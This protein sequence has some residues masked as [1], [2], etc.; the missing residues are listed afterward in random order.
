MGNKQ[1]KGGNPGFKENIGHL[2]SNAELGQKLKNVKLLSEYDSAQLEKLAAVVKMEEHNAGTMIVKQGESGRGFYIIEKGRVEVL[3]DESG[4]ESKIADLYVGDYFGEFALLHNAARGASVRAKEHTTTF[5]LGRDDFQTLFDTRTLT[6][7]KRVAVSA[8][9]EDNSYKPPSGASKEKTDAQV[10]LILEAI[11]QSPLF[12]DL[13]LELK[14]QVIA[15]MHCETIAAGEKV[16]LQGDKKGDLFYAVEEGEFDIFVDGN[17]VSVYGRQ[18]CFGDLALMYNAPRAATVQAKVV[19]KVWVMH[20]AI[21]RQ[22][23]QKVSTQALDKYSGFLESVKL[24]KDLNDADRHKL[25]D[26]LEERHFQAGDVIFEQGV[27]G[28]VMYIIKS[29]K[30]SIFRDGEEV[31]KCEAGTY[32]GELALLSSNKRAASPKAMTDCVLLEMSRQTFNE[33]LGPLTKTLES[34]T[35]S[36]RRKN[37][38]TDEAKLDEWIDVPFDDLD[39]VGV[40]GTGSFGFVKLVKNKHNNDQTFALKAVSKAVIVETGQQGHIL[41]EKNVMM[42]LRHPFL[43]RLYQTYKDRDRLYFLLEPVLGGELFTHLR[44]ETLFEEKTTRFYASCVVLA[45]EYM[46]DLDIIYRDLKPENLLIDKDGYIKVTDFGFAK[47]VD[48]GKTWTLCG[49]PDY[50]APELVA[51][52]GHNKGVDWWTVGILIWEMLASMPPFYDE[53]QMKT[54]R[55]IV[56]DAPLEFP[57]HFSDEARSL[58]KKLLHK[59]PTRRLGVIK[60]G[61]SLV[62]KHRWFD[63]LGASA[64]GSRSGGWA[65]LTAKKIE[66]PWKPPISSNEDLKNFDEVDESEEVEPYSDDGTN[67]DASF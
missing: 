17:Q 39:V 43:I 54:Y 4:V 16:I 47:K 27:E 57:S 45:F 30:I 48:S 9:L 56:S 59:K 26:A 38:E 28:D 14:K 58:L 65:Q 23:V 52:K 10:S 21:F 46:H 37:D 49:T 61:A 64:G 62:K 11:R 63:A 31:M 51:G 15:Q 60:G 2:Q 50:L 67:W 35:Q 13:D 25:A 53:D 34:A 18:T 41:S 12:L 29:G 33:L 3:R 22:T 36:Y 8:G 5:F 7:S 19:S 1:G 44:R 32:F 6:F 66:A 55:R 20:R 42:K 24:L 40:L